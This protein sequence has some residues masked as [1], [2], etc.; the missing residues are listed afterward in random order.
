[1]STDSEFLKRIWPGV[2]KATQWLIVQDGNG[3]GLIEGAQHNTLDT[4]WFGASAWLSGLYQSA[5]QAAASMADE[6]QDEEFAKTCRAITT[7]GKGKLVSE[8]FNGE[9]FQNKIDPAHLDAIN[10]GSGCLIDQVSGQTWARQVGLP[11][12]FPEKETQSA[13]KALWRYNFA[14]DAGSYLKSNQYGRCYATVGES[15]L[16]ICT[17]PKDDWKFE[18]AKGKGPGWAAGYFNECQNGYEHQAAGGMIWEGLVQE[19]LAVERA[20]HDRYSASKRNPYNE[21]ECGDHYGRATASYGVFLAACGY[22]YNGPKK[23][24]GFAPKIHPEKFKAAFTSAEGWGSFSQNIVHGKTEA[25]LILKH[26]KLALQSFS[27][28]SKE[29]ITKAVVTLNG[30]PVESSVSMNSDKAVVTFAKEVIL[31]A[32]DELSIHLTR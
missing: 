31:S 28:G 4:D 3:D 12:I 20:I 18:N 16:L 9:Y 2:K 14:P 32:N 24:L 17:F 8:L 21:I 22:E 10:S 30:K 6:M 19:G 13:L 23:H 11:R 29:P 7:I 5:L 26:G 1:M 15:G 27:L 25:S